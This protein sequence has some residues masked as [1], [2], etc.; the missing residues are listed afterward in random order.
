MKFLF[1]IPLLFFIFFS[2]NTF[3]QFDDE[4]ESPL[5]VAVKAN[6]LKE[7]KRLVEA[8]EPIDTEYH[9]DD[10]ALSIAM[11]NDYRD[12][13]LYLLSKGAKSR[14]NFYNAVSKGDLAWIKTLRSYDFYDSEAMIPAVESGN[15]EIVKYLI[16]EKFPVD[17]EQ[18]RRTG[19]FKKYYISPLELAMDNHSDA[20]V[21]ELVKG[22][23][24]LTEAFYDAALFEYNDLGKKLVDFGKQTNEL[25]LISAQTGNI[26]LLNYCL[27]KGADKTTKDLQGKNA[28]LLAAHH[29]RADMY[30]YCVTTLGLSPTSVSAENENALMLACRS[31]NAGLIIELLASNQNLEFQNAK[32]ETVLFYAERCEVPEIFALVLAKNPVI[33]HKDN[34]GNTVLLKAALAERTAHVNLLIEKGADVY[35]KTKDGLNLIGCLLNNYSKN[36]T[37]ILNL[38]EKGVDPKVK[39]ADGK[40]FAFIAIERGDTTLLKLL[41]S[42]GISVDGRNSYGQRPSIKNVELIKFII[43]NGGDPN[44]RDSWSNTYLCTA[45]EM[46][47]LELAAFL[48]KH[49]A[50]INIPSCFMDEMLLFEAIKKD[51]LN[52][53]QFLVESK[54]DLYVKTRW[55]KNVMEVAIEENNPEII[56]YLR[57][58]GAMTKEELNKREVER[59]IEMQQFGTMVS[60]KKVSAIIALLNKYPELV[61][62]TEEQKS[63]AHLCAE[64]NSVELLQILFDRIHWKINDQLNFEQQTMLHIAAKQESKDFVVFLVKKGAE[65]HQE[66]A[67][68]KQAIDYAKNKEIKQYLKSLK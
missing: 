1:F 10:D 41:K 40:E 9:F 66:D 49:N 20:M 58:K 4:V 63:L 60:E 18:K 22:G 3:S 16:S 13:V 25:F 23:A 55:S 21:L 48:V 56:A 37:L 46:N 30:H 19:I 28:L 5:V 11:S 42:K 14:P 68:G 33:D 17:F 35:V 12:I 67:F 54:A 32:G 50:D 27:A 45:L 39:S 38:I 7:V 53:V 8:G 31:D 65:I 64:K 61:L 29:G 34:E 15:I 62:G 59:A 44:A 52:F 36:E 57:S 2:G 47:D 26:P 24:P 43:E 51:N 6:N